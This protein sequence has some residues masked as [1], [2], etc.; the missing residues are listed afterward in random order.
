MPSESIRSAA[1]RKILFWLSRG[2]STVSE[3]SKQFDMRMPHASLACR[4]LRA[5]GYVLRDESGG[6]RNAP[7]YLSQ[8]GLERLE[9]DGL[10]KLKRHVSVIPANTDAVV[11]QSESSN[12]LLGYVKPPS[13]SLF[14]IPDAMN[15]QGQT[16][17]G[18]QGGTWI[19]FPVDKIK[20]YMLDDFSPTSAPSAT[21]SGTLADFGSTPTKI[22]LARGKVLEQDPLTT[23][24][25]GQWFSNTVEP[26]TPPQ[27]LFNGDHCLGQVSGTSLQYF[28]PSG[29]TAHLPHELDR[30]L[31]VEALGE[32]AICLTDGQGRRERKLPIPILRQWL[33]LRHTRMSVNRIEVMYES[34]RSDLL[35]NTSK[36]PQS[37]R[38]DI[39]SDFGDVQ[40]SVDEVNEGTIDTYGMSVNGLSALISYLIQDS[41]WPC[42]VD[43]PFEEPDEDF[44]QRLTF[45]PKC[46]LFMTRRGTGH[47]VS[48]GSTHLVTSPNLAEVYA[49]IGCDSSLPIVLNSPS[50]PSQS[51]SPPRE[52]MPRNATELLAPLVANEAAIFTS[53][54]PKGRHGDAISHSLNVFPKGDARMA[55]EL[56]STH[57]LAA[58][59]AS[60]EAERSQRWLRTHPDLPDGW[61][62]LLKVDALD[63]VDL[64]EAIAKATHQWQTLALR[65]LKANL[66]HAPKV[67]LSFAQALDESPVAP[68]YATALVAS[69]HL[70]DDTYSDLFDQA[71]LSWLDTPHMAVEVIEHLF[72]SA[73]DPLTNTR[74]ETCL[75][76]ARIH[77]KSS[78]L[79]LWSRGIDALQQNLP[80]TTE[81]QRQIMTLLPHSWWLPY[82]NEWIV[83]Q[84]NTASG[85][86]WLSQ[87]PLPWLAII[88]RTEGERCGFPGHEVHHPGCQLT[89]EDLLGIHLLPDGPGSGP[90]RDLFQAIY[91]RDHQLPVPIVS[92]HGDGAWLVQPIETWPML[93]ATVMHHGDEVIGRV[94]FGRSFAYRMSSASPMK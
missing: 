83:N 19:L 22:G 89:G 59:I 21:T 55:N 11:V 54:L 3:I 35:K 14:F 84:L 42:V 10:E 4:Q 50:S 76:A 40:W 8:T 46:R 87:N 85:R 24:I 82:G 53:P 92:S 43:W 7:M 75:K 51:S 63:L 58:W 28:P 27:F 66:P 6:L 32:G 86:V 37:L 36:I 17:T 62:D 65:R 68:W 93:G 5:Q 9:N 72:G 69:L 48:K 70:A 16:S 33:G 56:E 18:N 12:V 41:Q 1:H 60:P 23:L 64:P 52:Y 44:Y 38:K 71:L 73:D 15:H 57:P 20:W 79:Y 78:L 29:I 61:A 80:W 30:S 45:H 13:S 39:F 90:L 31:V 88:G 34:I 74:L 25:E 77:P 47:S 67:A 91:A 81:L 26:R 94:L 2:P 49:Q